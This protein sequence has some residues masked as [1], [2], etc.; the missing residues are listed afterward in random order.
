[1]LTKL[2]LRMLP[3]HHHHRHHHYYHHHTYTHTHTHARTHTHTHTHTQ[4]HTH[5]H[6]HTHTHTRT[7]THTHTQFNRYIGV[8][9]SLIGIVLTALPILLI[10][11]LR[12]QLRYQILLNLV[13]ALGGALVLFC[14]LTVPTTT[15]S[16]RVVSFLALYFWIASLLWMMI[17]AYDLFVVLKQN[18]A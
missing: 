14:F 16:C 5:T 10:R 2:R 12:K 11:A 1:V 15:V 9:L 3:P 4:T 18:P 7:H 17:E 13:A 6:A 8:G